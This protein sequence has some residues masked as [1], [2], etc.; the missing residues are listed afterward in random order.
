TRVRSQGAIGLATVASQPGL[1]SEAEMPAWRARAAEL[2]ASSTVPDVVFPLIFLV[3]Q[4]AGP[5]AADNAAALAGLGEV[6]RT[7]MLS[8]THPFAG[9]TAYGL[10]QGDDAAWQ[11]FAASLEGAELSQLIKLLLQNPA[12]FCG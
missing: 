8:V 10:T 5:A 4:T 3:Q 11:A 6:L 9:C 12:A 2:V 1:I 7:P